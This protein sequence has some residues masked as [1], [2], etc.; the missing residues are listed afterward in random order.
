[1]RYK[2]EIFFETEQSRDIVIKI[3]NKSKAEGA[4]S[5]LDFGNLT[6]ALKNM[7]LIEE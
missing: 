1:M 4:L 3:L 5:P 2:L 7:T 6:T